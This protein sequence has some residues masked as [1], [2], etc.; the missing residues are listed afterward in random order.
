M[1]LEIN[2]HRMEIEITQDGN[3]D[4][5]TGETESMTI[6][7]DGMWMDES[8]RGYAVLRTEGWSI[9]DGAE[10]AQVI[11]AVQDAA[12]ALTQKLRIISVKG[13]GNESDI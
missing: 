2:T 9:N 6:E 12:E 5:T 10:M 1:S 7:I 3:T 4:G 11:D 8:G 13:A